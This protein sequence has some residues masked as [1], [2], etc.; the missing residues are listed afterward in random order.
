MG[1]LKDF[2][3]GTAFAIGEV[4]RMTRTEREEK[5]NMTPELQ[6]AVDNL[7]K[8]AEAGDVGAMAN[9]GDAYFNGTQLRYDP[10]E[11]CKW[12]TKAAEAGHV[13]SMY[14]LGLLY[15][16]DIS[17]QFYNDKL[18]AHWLYEASIRGDREAQE[19]LN[20]KYSYNKFLKRWAR[21]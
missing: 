19:V 9:L 10:Y 17:K 14:N 3:D 7:T 12:W 18:A 21:R 16:G 2:L 15:T 20:E 6:R 5:E 1:F 4:A 8:R 13:N 11:A